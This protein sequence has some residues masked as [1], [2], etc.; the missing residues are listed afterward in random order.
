MLDTLLMNTL[1]KAIATGTHLLLV[2]DADRTVPPAQAAQIAPRLRDATLQ[3]LPGLGHLAH[4]E[5]PAWF[6]ERLAGWFS[7]PG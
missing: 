2:G 1:L 3:R 7:P 6:A 4:E 5:Q